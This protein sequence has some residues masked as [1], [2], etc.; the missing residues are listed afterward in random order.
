MDMDM[1]MDMD[2]GMGSTTEV[3]EVYTGKRL[4]LPITCTSD[5]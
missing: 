5:S 4:T 2:D 3:V 1:D